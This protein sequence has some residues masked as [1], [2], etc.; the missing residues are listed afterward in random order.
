MHYW[1]CFQQYIWDWTRKE[2][3][4]KVQG[5]RVGSGEVMPGRGGS[6]KGELFH[7][8][9]SGCLELDPEGRLWEIMWNPQLRGEE[10][11]ALPSLKTLVE[12]CP[13]PVG[14]NF[15][16]LLACHAVAHLG[17]S[18]FRHSK[19]QLLVIGS[20]PDTS[21]HNGPRATVGHWKCHFSNFR[22]SDKQKKENK[23]KS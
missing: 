15:L 23:V 22:L 16:A 17:N 1:G 11:I 6:Q 8:H 13:V 19:G 5:K 2:F 10:I 12:D 20:Q 7:Q 21:T 18:S 14:I 9:Y 3:T 4:W